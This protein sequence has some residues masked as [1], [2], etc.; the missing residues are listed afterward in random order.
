MRVQ[1]LVLFQ[2]RGKVYWGEAVEKSLES[3]HLG[4]QL[5]K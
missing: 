1:P 3:P 4:K 2:A 5:G